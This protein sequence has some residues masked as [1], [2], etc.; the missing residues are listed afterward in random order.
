MKVLHMLFI[1]ALGVSL[2]N[3]A[4]HAGEKAARRAVQTLAPD[5]KVSSVKMSSLSGIYEVV[6][7]G[8]RGPMVVYASGD[9]RHVLAGELLD[10]T[11]R[12]NL[13]SERMDAL[14]AIDFDSLPLERAIKTVKGNGKRRVAV[15]SDPD[16][17]YCRKLEPELAKLSDV[18]IYTFLYPLPMHQDAARKAKLVWCS[19]DRAKAWD[20]L[21]LRGKLPEGG[22]TDCDHP[23][24]E[25]LALGQKLSIDG[26]P[27]LIFANGK[28]VPGYAEA[29]QLE[30]LLRTAGGK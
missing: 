15:F 5:A 22:K 18:T 17:P 7:D 20:D 21:M 13:T 25:T 27:A 30:R 3:T 4:V 8:P 23:V 9:G 28:R 26:T 19:K 6:L 2:A 16:C 24:D 10:V 14:T 12:R 11:S 29:A 1:A